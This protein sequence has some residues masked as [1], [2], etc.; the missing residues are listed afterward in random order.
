MFLLSTSDWIKFVVCILAPIPL[1]MSLSHNKIMGFIVGIL[2]GFFLSFTILTIDCKTRT[3]DKAGSPDYIQISKLSLTT[4]A[5]FLVFSILYVVSENLKSNPLLKLEVIL[6]RSIL[7]SLIVS[8]L[9]FSY[10]Y[11]LQKEGTYCIVP[12]P[13]K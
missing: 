3:D 1:I 11:Y 10:I 6:I 4:T 12:P 5:I 2:I 8:G 9:S 7:G 13:T